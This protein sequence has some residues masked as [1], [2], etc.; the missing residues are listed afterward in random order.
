V[1]SDLDVTRH[2]SRYVR[3]KYG[4][5]HPPEGRNKTAELIRLEFF[6]HFCVVDANA[7]CDVSVRPSD[8]PWGAGLCRIR[9]YQELLD[10]LSGSGEV[11][12][13]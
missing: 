4:R 7:K 5:R 10:G 8:N 12:K 1:L 9:C 11:E 6:E 2:A 3:R 13:D